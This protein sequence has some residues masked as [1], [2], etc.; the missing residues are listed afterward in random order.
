MFYFNVLVYYYIFIIYISGSSEIC[1]S[2]VSRG[3]AITGDIDVQVDTSM[4]DPVC[5]RCGYLD[6]FTV[7]LVTDTDNVTYHTGE[8][9]IVKFTDISVTKN[10]LIL[11]DPANT[12]SDG[13]SIVCRFTPPG[14]LEVS[15]NITIE[16]ICKK[17]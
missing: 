4:P 12:F 7:V 16:H 2:G 13:T 17:V 10:G 5:I 8:N 15:H 3:L 11:N 9:V 6:G 14:S 1:S